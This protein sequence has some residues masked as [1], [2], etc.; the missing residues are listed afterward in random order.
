MIVKVRQLA[1]DERA[2]L[3]GFLTTLTPEQW[4]APTLCAG[5]QVHDVA[6]H[7][8]S[9][10]DV[11]PAALLAHLIRGRLRPS[12]VN[13]LMLARY[14]TSQPE[15]L[16]ARL[17]ASPDPRSLPAALGW[18][19]ALVET[20]IHHQDIRHGLGLPRVIPAERLLPA[21]HIALIAPDVSHPWPLRGVRLVAT[22]V[23]FAAGVGP[24]VR[25]TG[26]ALLMTIAGRHESV[27]EL[28][29]PGKPRL[30]RHIGR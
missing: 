16:L 17:R 15:E 4:R 6:A 22:D 5:W 27:S 12:H 2:D 9:Y 23:R 14:E 20:L 10:D 1:L 19:V 25:G 7:V 24:A 29:G 26:E 11:R 3:A 30:T 28:S 18:R 21:L 13:A 8:V